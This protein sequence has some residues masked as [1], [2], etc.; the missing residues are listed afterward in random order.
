MGLEATSFGED[1]GGRE[2]SVKEKPQE[3]S[4]GSLLGSVG[5]YSWVQVC[6]WRVS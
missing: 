6:N 1:R 4:T 2:E 5:K 3:F